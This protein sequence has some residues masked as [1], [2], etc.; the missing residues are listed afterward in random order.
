MDEIGR[1][2][3]VLGLA[4]GELE[5]GVVDSYYGPRELREEALRAASDAATARRRSRRA[6][7]A[8]QQ[9]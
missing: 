5:E 9:R 2:Y 1:D 8:R 4:V 7:R 6:A 3:V